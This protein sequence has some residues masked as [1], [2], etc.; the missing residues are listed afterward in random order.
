[1]KNYIFVLLLFLSPVAYAQNMAQNSANPDFAEPLQK[2]ASPVVVELFSSQNC[3]ACPPADA[4]LKTLAGSDNVI[5]LSCHVDYFGK[6]SANLGRQFCTDR[7]SRYIKQIKRKSHFTPQMMVNG[8]MSEIGY[9]TTA[10]SAAIMKARSERTLEIA[11]QPKSAGVYDFML[12][13]GK[14]GGETDLIL[15]VY[16]KPHTVPHRGKTTI[17]KNVMSR[18][19]PLGTWGGRPMQS[20]VYPL[21]STNSAGFVIMA[22]ERVSGKILAAGD[23]KL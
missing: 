11:I 5:A 16:D 6:T 18:L 3:P 20:A 15:V 2:T 10:V 4:Y 14:V 12:P 19:L 23:Y 1:M 7:Q 13:A 9:E 8:H 21:I 17:Y 22:Q